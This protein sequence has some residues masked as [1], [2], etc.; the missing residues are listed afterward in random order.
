MDCAATVVYIYC[1][2]KGQ[3]HCQLASSKNE[4]KEFLL[5]TI[6]T[7]TCLIESNSVLLPFKTVA[8]Y[9]PTSRYCPCVVY[10]SQDKQTAP[11]K[12]GSKICILLTLSLLLG[13]LALWWSCSSS[14]FLFFLSCL[15]LFVCLWFCLLTLLLRFPCQSWGRS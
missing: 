13:S 4:K 6:C 7:T 11:I 3:R 9:K 12:I 1:D 15:G 14:F 8:P 5:T 2:G 10:N